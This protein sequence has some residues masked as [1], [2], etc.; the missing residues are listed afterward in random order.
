MRS[1]RRGYGPSKHLQRQRARRERMRQQEE[2]RQQ[3]ERKLADY[4]P[5]KGY[6]PGDDI[7]ETQDH[8]D[9]DDRNRRS[10]L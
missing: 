3:Q 1:G 9:Q 4:K 10:G 2:E 8:S 7:D 5:P 6:G